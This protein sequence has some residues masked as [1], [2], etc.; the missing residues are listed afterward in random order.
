MQA[1]FIE[2]FS[3]DHNMIVEEFEFYQQLPPKMQNELVDQIFQEILK[4]FSH[5]FAYTDV[6]FR[7]E[8]IVQMYSRRYAPEADII[9]HG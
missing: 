7:N 1:S 9:W 2:S 6:G 8:L 4:K 5:F 3:A